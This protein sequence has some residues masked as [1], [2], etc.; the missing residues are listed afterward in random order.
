MNISLRRR[1]TSGYSLAELLVVVAIIGVLSLVSVPAFMNYRNSAK[2][3]SSMRQFVADLRWARQRAIT[4][5][6][7]TMISFKTGAG[8]IVYRDFNGEVAPDGTVSYSAVTPASKYEKRFDPDV[9]FA[10]STSVCLFDDTITTPAQTNGWNDIV[11][12]A[13]GTVSNVPTADECKDNG[14]ITGMA[15]IRIDKGNLERRTYKFNV[16]PAGRIRVE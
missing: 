6:H 11:F 16:N 10:P 9:Y 8:Q 13:N 7:P 5:N 2:L 12:N 1:S 4:E 3:K 15:L 14:V